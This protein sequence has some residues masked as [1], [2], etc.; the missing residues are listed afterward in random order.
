[1]GAKAAQEIH[2]AKLEAAKAQS[3]QKAAEAE[4]SRKVQAAQSEA[5]Q[6]QSARKA[7]E[8]KASQAESE[9]AQAQSAQRT[10][11]TKAAQQIRFLD[12]RT[13]QQVN[14][15]QSQAAHAESVKKTSQAKANT[16]ETIMAG[17]II[18]LLIFSAIAGKT[19]QGRAF[20][21]RMSE[22]IS[23]V[24]GRKNEKRQPLLDKANAVS[25]LDEIKRRGLDQRGP[26]IGA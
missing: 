23:G 5:A 10:E 25:P 21:E 18:L 3:L 14:S 12:A 16:G 1:M 15:A 9:A 13:A 7:A 22:R 19:P 20:K 26:F 6:A 17:T 8:A 4:A 24:V 2:S 11:E